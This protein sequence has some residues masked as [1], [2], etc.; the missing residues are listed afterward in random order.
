MSDWRTFD[1][2][3]ETYDRVRA[4]VHAAPARDLVELVA[5][6]RAARVLDVGTGTGVAAE[7]AAATVGSEGLVVGIDPSLPM[8]RLA[9]P[10]HPRVL[11]AQAIDLPFRD[12]T[13]DAVLANFVI[14]FFTK[15]ETALFDMLRVLRPGGTLG[16]SWWGGGP[17]EFVRTWTE[18]AET[19][20]TKELFRDSQG[21]IP[22][23]ERFRD[24]HLLE[25]TLRDAG[26][27]EVQVYRR[28]YRST[29]SQ[30]DY[31]A[32]RETSSE[33]RFLREA[34]GE[35]LWERFR[36]RAADAF[37]ER[38]PDPFGDTNDVLIAVGTKG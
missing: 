3:A 9:R 33:G 28:Q 7:A 35:P 16:V 4:P 26:L 23:N 32:G 1:T 14:A 17:D 6:P 37:R 19:F 27:R 10:R 34:L 21:A 20:A 38:F 11:A 13:F 36:E 5:L 12:E 24:R 2:V 22:W 31:L 15:Y 25:E 8:L 18:L 30:A 29:M